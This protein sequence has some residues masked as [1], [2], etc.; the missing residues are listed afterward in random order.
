MT[1]FRGDKIYQRLH[2]A[3]LTDDNEIIGYGSEYSDTNGL[4]TF[5][6][7]TDCDGSLL[8]VKYIEPYKRELY[9]YPNP[10]NDVFYCS[11]ENVMRI[12]AFNMAGSLVKISDDNKIDLSGFP[13]G[14]YFLETISGEIVEVKKVVLN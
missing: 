11:S 2:S 6:F 1:F 3:V 14:L 10:S 5:L 4:R 8:S 9:F 12:R 7:K 13:P